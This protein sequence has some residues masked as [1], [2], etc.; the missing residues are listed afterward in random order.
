MPAS[1]RKAKRLRRRGAGPEDVVGLCLEKS[2][3]WVAALLASWWAGAAFLPLDPH[4]PPERLAFLVRDAGLRQLLDVGTGLWTALGCIAGLLQRERTGKGMVVDASL[5]E[6]ALG[7]LAGH[8]AG[9]RVSGALPLNTA[10]LSA[11]AFQSPPRT[12]IGQPSLTISF[13]PSSPPAAT[14]SGR[15]RSRVC[16][17]APG[18]SGRRAW[19][20]RA[21]ASEIDELPELAAAAPAL[22]AAV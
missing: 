22:G 1:T 17:S 18:R 2:P 3:E 20:R 9:F 13:A 12:A 11:D 14:M 19:M 5:F 8:F 16:G 21:C 10:R 15:Q 7:W 6:T 4:L